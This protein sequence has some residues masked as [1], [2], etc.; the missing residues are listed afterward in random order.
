MAT[1]FSIIDTLTVK[2]ALKL[3]EPGTAFFLDANSINFND[4]VAAPTLGLCVW[5]SDSISLSDVATD[6]VK[7]ALPFPLPGATPDR[8]LLLDEVSVK[9]NAGGLTVSVSDLFN[10]RDLQSSQNTNSPGVADSLSISD[11][12]LNGPGWTISPD[13]LSLSDTVAFSLNSIFFNLSATCSDSLALADKLK[14]SVPGK[15]NLLSDNL[16]LSDTI[17]IS[18]TSNFLP[19]LRRYLNDV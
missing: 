10:F 1:T 2:D 9:L 6:A 4:T 16:A 18:M 13:S 8:I 7:F 12:L 5:A 15:L 14:L 19:Y 11:T 17:S 3:L